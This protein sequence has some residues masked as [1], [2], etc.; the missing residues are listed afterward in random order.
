MES[1]F[2]KLAEQV[3]D[4]ISKQGPIQG[5]VY[6][7][8]AREF[9]VEVADSK[10]ENLK[11]AHD[12][13][14]GIR[15][16]TDHRLGCA[17]TSDLSKS[18]L[19]RVVEQALNNARELEP[20][21]NWELPVKNNKG[22]ELQIYDEDTFLT[23][24]EEKISLA[25][26]I[27]EA[28]R[29][30]DTRVKIT[31]KAA[32]HDS[33]YKVLV[34][35]TNGLKRDYIGSYCGGYAVVIGEDQGESET[36]FGL[37]YKL[38]FKDLNPLKIGR[39]AG[40]KAI[41]MLGAKTMDS[42][43]IPVIL[44]PYTATNFLGLFQMAFSGE[45]VIKGKSFFKDKIGNPVASKTVT[46]IDDGTMP[47]LIG[48]LPYDGEGT[49]TSRTVLVQDGELGGYLHNHYT[50]RKM[51]TKSTGN[52][53]RD[54]YKNTPEVGTTNFFIQEGTFS[55][56]HILEGITKGLYIT[57]VMG[58]HTANPISGDFSIG[59]SGIVIENGQLTYPVK[60]IAIAGNLRELLFDVEA[61]GNDLTF[62]INRGAPTIRIKNISV[63]GN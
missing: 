50:A 56:E 29:N 52:S 12:R 45:A 5:E 32:Y 27:E 8:D 39:E 36:G 49:P 16:L 25:Q 34:Y 3:L 26:R 43:H 9:T 17:Y 53:V 20:D 21:E 51:G 54:S 6:I 37:D 42:S 18:S 60:G 47:G 44:D 19:E 40:E 46:I 4:R 31:E 62:F 33:R 59:A 28:A 58:M 57:D 30:Y 13:G 41:R 23:S 35:N 11:L 7:Q 55:P 15:V 24:V 10:V 61:L 22:S 2:E 38:R 48:S 14:I 1:D 63:S